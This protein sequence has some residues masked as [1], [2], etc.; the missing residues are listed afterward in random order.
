MIKII[1]GWSN[2][3]GSTFAFINLMKE[4][5]K[6]GHEA[7][8]YGPHDW[9]LDK[10]NGAMLKDFKPEADDIII[11]HFLQLQG[12]PPVKK[13]VLSCHEKDV[14]EVSNVAKYW[15]TVIFI[16]E[17]QRKYHKGFFGDYEIIPNV[18]VDFEMKPKSEE[19][20]KTAGIIGSFDVNKQT[21]ISI[22]RALNDGFEKVLLFGGVSDS[23]YYNEFVKPL[24]DKHDNVIEHGFVED[25]QEMYDKIGVAYISSKSEV[26]CLVKDECISTGTEFRGNH[27]TNNDTPDMTNEEI[28]NKWIKVLDL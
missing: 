13:I 18:K 9:H 7:I 28:I 15:D 10:C 23:N 19:A 8:L 11:S 20:K 27:A 6:A 24:I 16:N 3:G 4:L 22:E 25:K 21:H 26:A 12:R 2:K 5:K 14:F 1:T 17:K